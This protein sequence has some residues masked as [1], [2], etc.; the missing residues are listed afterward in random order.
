MGDN[1]V[2]AEEDLAPWIL[3]PV[4]QRLRQGQGEFLAE[5][6][7]AIV[8]FLNFTGID[9]DDDP[10]AGEKLNAYVSWAQQEVSRYEGYLLQLIVGDKGNYLYGAFGAPIA[11]EDDAL[12]AVSAA[13][14]LLNPPE[15]LSYI[16]GTK[17]G[18]SQ[19]RLRTGAYGGSQR[20]TYGVLGDDVNLA[21]RLM[22]AAEPGQILTNLT[23]KQSTGQQ[24]RWSPNESTIRVKGKSEPI[25]V[26]SP[27]GVQPRQA[28]SMT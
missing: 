21:A 25:R 9:F 23:V 18:I 15:N 24:F 10:E 20:R 19:G 16:Q 11:H 13:L 17:I 3:P 22:Q 27:V 4:Y 2:F 5:L 12:R 6:R 8:F 1:E 26:F 28:W 7:P 14:N